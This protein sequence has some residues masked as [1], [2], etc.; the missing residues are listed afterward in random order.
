M[1]TVRFGPDS[2][3]SEGRLSGEGTKD[4]EIRNEFKSCLSHRITTQQ[5]DAR[6]ADS[7]STPPKIWSEVTDNYRYG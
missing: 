6:K 7:G 3:Y 4:R 1:S 5:V 2:G